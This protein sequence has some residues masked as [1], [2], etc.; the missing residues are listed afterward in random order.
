MPA[1]TIRLSE[2]RELRANPPTRGRP[3]KVRPVK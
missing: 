1:M 2:V 3:V